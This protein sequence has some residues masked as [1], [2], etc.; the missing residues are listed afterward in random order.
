MSAKSYVTVLFGIVV[1]FAWFNSLRIVRERAGAVD[2][3]RSLP[4]VH[5]F[6]GVMTVVEL[7]LVAS[8][9]FGA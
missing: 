9:L 1:V 6:T 8:L 4:L 2:Q 7:I 3:A 5:I